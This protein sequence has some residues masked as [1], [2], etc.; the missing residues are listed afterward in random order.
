METTP[1]IHNSATKGDIA[2]KVLMPGDPLRAQ[3]IAENYLENPVKYNSLRGMSGYT[4]LYKG[5]K[6]SI[7]GSGMGSPSMC[8]YA[9]EL[10]SFYDVQSII[11]VGSTG[12][13]NENQPL[14]SLIL[15]MSACTDSNFQYH[16]GLKGQFSPT[17]DYGLLRKASDSADELNVNYKV[18]SIL[19]SDVFYFNNMETLLQWSSMGVLAVDM[20]TAGLYTVAA[21]A[22]KKALSILTVSDN[23]VTHEKISAEARQDSFDNMIYVALSL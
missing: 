10:F 2:P 11:R 19:T 6:V 3:F 20:E 15:A 13:L 17:A 1:T 9:H 14:N 7:Q 18:G 5:E 8:L 4:G 23:V 21:A 16:Y 12:A 22:G